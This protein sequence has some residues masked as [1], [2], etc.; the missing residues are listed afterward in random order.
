MT[1]M[2]Y[3]TQQAMFNNVTMAYW[4]N[5][6]EELAWQSGQIC[7]DNDCTEESCQCGSVAYI[8]ADGVL[9]D[10]CAPDYWQGWGSDD[11]ERS[12]G[13][14]AI[15]LPWYGDGADLKESVDNDLPWDFS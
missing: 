1:Q 2:D 3:K 5:L 8:A 13:I 12:G 4:Q 14:A 10:I 7:Q 11:Y 9:S 6:A 15:C